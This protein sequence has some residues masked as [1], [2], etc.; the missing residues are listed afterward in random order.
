MESPKEKERKK[1]KNSIPNFSLA[2]K[3]MESP[4]KEGRIK[5]EW[6]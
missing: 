3:I 5:K 1:L 6:I 2:D 4:T